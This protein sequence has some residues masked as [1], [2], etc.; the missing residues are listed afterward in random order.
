MN[1]KSVIK[2]K[3]FTIVKVASMMTSK[4]GKP[5]SDGSLNRA[6]TKNPT[7]ETLR[8][9]AEVIGANINEF[10]EDELPKKDE[11]SALSLEGMID[12]GIIELDGKKYR[13]LF[14]P[15]EDSNE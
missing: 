13:Q 9:I 7:V 1:V 15:I 6:I 8:Q 14:V 10:F 4:N 5:V 11:S 12:S 2:K 3:G